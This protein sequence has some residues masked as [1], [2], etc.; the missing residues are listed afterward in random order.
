MSQAKTASKLL[1]PIHWAVVVAPMAICVRILR[2]LHHNSVQT[3]VV[4]MLIKLAATS[5]I[6]R[7]AS[8]VEATTAMVTTTAMTITDITATIATLTA[9]ATTTTTT[10][11][12]YQKCHAMK[13][14]VIA[15]VGVTMVE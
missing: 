4:P 6:M 13:Y 9:A 1:R 8:K 2:V 3:D 7:G 11:I 5:L 14:M 10:T 12:T 15:T